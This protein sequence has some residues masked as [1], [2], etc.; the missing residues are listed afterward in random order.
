MLHVWHAL[1]NFPHFNFK[2]REPIFGLLP[3]SS[4]PLKSASCYQVWIPF[5]LL[6]N[7]HGFPKKGQPQLLDTRKL[8]WMFEIGIKGL[9]VQVGLQVA[10]IIGTCC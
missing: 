9:S 6:D 2:V 10:P 1:T 8:E 3:N 4:H 7:N 5:L